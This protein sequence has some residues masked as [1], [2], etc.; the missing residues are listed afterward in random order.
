MGRAPPL[1]DSDWIQQHPDTH[2]VRGL[3]VTG[4]DHPQ[5]KFN[6]FSTDEAVLYDLG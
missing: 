1:I 2:L 5:E 4:P 3:R 6:K